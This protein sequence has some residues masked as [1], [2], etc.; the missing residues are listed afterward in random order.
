MTQPLSFDRVADIYDAT[1]GLPPRVVERV[2]DRIIAASHA[3]PDTRFLEIGIGTGR[4]A[5][6]L[7]QHGYPVT[8]IDVSSRMMAVLRAKV[9]DA[10]NLTLLQGDVTNLPF[11]DDSFD[12][13]LAVHI[14]HLI[15]EWRR[16]L[17]DVQR[18][19][20][21]GGF[22]VRGHD[23]S[24]PDQP[25]SEIRRRW[26]TLVREAGGQLRPEYG[27][28]EAV[29]TELTERGARTAVYRVATWVEESRPIDLLEELR[30]R[31][32]SATWSVLDETLESVHPQMLAWA[33]ERYG[34]LSAPLSTRL[35]FL[36]TVSRFPA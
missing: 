33:Q 21:P 25:G 19:L 14:L 32:Y 36:L 22:L 6:P 24:V 7:V 30:Q 13:V 16:A 5:L 3:T 15:P 23:R 10:A 4:I 1:R 18:V 17:D 29:E 8:G 31:T 20:R 35:E 28:W 11:P 34:D 12:V 2:A 9:P 26:H 27:T